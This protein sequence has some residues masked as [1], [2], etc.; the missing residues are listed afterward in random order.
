MQ[1]KVYLLAILFFSLFAVKVFGIEHIH[2]SSEADAK[3]DCA[4]NRGPC[5]KIIG[6]D[7]I[8][9]EFNINPKPVKSMSDLLFTVIVKGEKEPVSDAAV[10]VDLTMPG[11]F[12]GVNRPLLKYLKD[13]KYEGR[14]T[15][16]I[17]PHGG[18]LWKAD[19]KVVREGKTASVS[20][21]FEV[22]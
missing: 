7:H 1:N 9:V 8:Q 2:S 4:I 11:M 21:F 19:V 15:L 13:G 3:A 17:C 6:K 14:G 10:S 22:D 5:L 20:F 12:M 16:P 18:K